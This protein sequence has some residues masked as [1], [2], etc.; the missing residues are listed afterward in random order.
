MT[1][2]NTRNNGFSTAESVMWINAGTS[3]YMLYETLLK[4]TTKYDVHMLWL[5][6]QA[7]YFFE[8]LVH[9][10]ASTWMGDHLWVGK[11]SWYVTGHL[12]QL[13]LP[14]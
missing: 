10:R 6:C 5:N 4:V 2:S 11:Q 3:A 12:E 7:T 1:G 8:S 9:C 13:S 14:S